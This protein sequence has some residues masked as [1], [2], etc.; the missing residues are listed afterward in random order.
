MN[1]SREEDS[2]FRL[3]SLL[4]RSLVNNTKRDPKDFQDFINLSQT[5]RKR[6]K[7]LRRNWQIVFDILLKKKNVAQVQRYDMPIQDRVCTAAFDRNSSRQTQEL[8]SLYEKLPV[9][10]DINK[11]VEFILNLQDSVVA[12]GGEVISS[13][14]DSISDYGSRGGSYPEFPWRMFQVKLPEQSQS[15]SSYKTFSSKMFQLDLSYSG[16]FSSEPSL[17]LDTVVREG[18]GGGGGGDGTEVGED[19]GYNSPSPLDI[20]QDVLTTP[21]CSRTTWESLGLRTSPQEKDFL[22]E[23]GGE[24]LHRVWRHGKSLTD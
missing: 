10:D 15:P 3:C 24:S 5:E 19:E 14:G 22:S 18:G 4:S 6:R 9:N 23:V 20:W 7:L 13:I 21:V 17:G 12:T 16:I 1:I 8:L 2:T 11:A